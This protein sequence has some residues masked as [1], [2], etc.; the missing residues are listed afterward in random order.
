MPPNLFTVHIQNT[1]QL[2]LPSL[3]I[4]TMLTRNGSTENAEIANSS[5]SIK[6]VSH[7]ADIVR[8]TIVKHVFLLREQTTTFTP[9]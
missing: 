7:L 8:P 3:T 4:L 5:E 6:Y 1:C 9:E 2:L